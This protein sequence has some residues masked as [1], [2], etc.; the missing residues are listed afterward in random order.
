M[1]EQHDRSADAAPP[2]LTVEVAAAPQ[3]PDLPPVQAR[4]PPAT[5]R[6]LWLAT[7]LVVVVLRWRFSR[8]ASVSYSVS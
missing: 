2:V 8:C 4:K 7:Y 1:S 5:T 6:I 3:P